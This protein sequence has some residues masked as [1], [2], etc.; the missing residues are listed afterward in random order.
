MIIYRSY[1]FRIWFSTACQEDLYRLWIGIYCS[2]WLFLLIMNKE[3]CK[4]VKEAYWWLLYRK[5]GG[6]LTKLICWHTAEGKYRGGMYGR[7][8]IW[9]RIRQWCFF[10]GVMSPN[11][12][13]IFPGT[14]LGHISKLRIRTRMLTYMVK[15]AAAL[16]VVLPRALTAVV[17]YDGEKV[18]S[19]E[20]G[21]NG[22]K[23]FT[24][25]V[26]L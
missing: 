13:I 20:D 1:E 21:T 10:Q 14:T 16:R 18:R 17:L 22:L 5:W 6:G 2:W 12:K 7:W 8:A 11:Y 25:T 24:V 3:V 9:L 26:E 23:E 15:A 19:V 4:R